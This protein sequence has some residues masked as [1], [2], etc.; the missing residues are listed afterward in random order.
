MPRSIDGATPNRRALHFSTVIEAIVT[1]DTIAASTVPSVRQSIAMI[2][3]LA[4]IADRTWIDVTNLATPPVLP[5]VA[6]MSVMIAVLNQKGGVGKST[7]ATNLAAASHLAGRSTLLID[8][9]RQATAFDWYAARA[10]GSQ[11]AGLDVRKADKIWTLRQFRDLA[12]DHEVIL[13]DGPARLNEI[14]Q[15]AAIAADI[16]LIPMKPGRAEW[17]AAAETQEMLDAADRIRSAVEMTP[18]RRVFVLND[19]FKNLPET[20]GLVEALAGAEVLTPILH[21][22]V[23]YQ[24]A[25][26]E[27]ESVLTTEPGSEAASEVR[28]LY[29]SL[30]V[31]TETCHVAA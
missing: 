15:A 14:G 31:A 18:V 28:A 19:A 6:A 21:H 13:C 23:A 1:A 24:R 22:R 30:F 5:I 27:G 9:D 8:L 26:G 20:R 3:A 25:L 2:A 7:L 10:E 12:K 11:L 4:A 16:V 29:K 17:W